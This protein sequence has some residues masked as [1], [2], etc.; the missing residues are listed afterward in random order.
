MSQDVRSGWHDS[1]YRLRFCKMQPLSLHVLLEN[2]HFP[3]GKVEG[4]VMSPWLTQLDND[5]GQGQNQGLAGR[6]VSSS[7]RFARRE[8]PCSSDPPPDRAQ[9]PCLTQMGTLR[10]RERQSPA[11][12]HTAD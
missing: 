2:G 1:V 3:R 9:D 5:R 12:D 11:Q 8:T 7:L 4:K 10:P 6:A